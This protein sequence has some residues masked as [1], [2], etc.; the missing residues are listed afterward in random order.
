M[1][2]KSIIISIVV[3]VAMLLVGLTY[4]LRGTDTVVIKESVGAISGPDVYSYMNVY[5][6]FSAKGGFTQG[7]GCVASSTTATTEIWTAAEMAAYNCFVYSGTTFAPAITITL[8]ASTTMT[9]LLP[10][11]G[12]MKEW[13]YDT[14]GYATATTTTF[15]AGTG[16]ILYEPDEGSAHDVVIAGAQSA[17]IKAWRRSDTDVAWLITEVSDAD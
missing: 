13:I 2:K 6:E 16:G 7:G 14:T 3:I 17:L 4:S 5:G 11:A 10:N 9:T 15:A 12:D 1:S 8:P